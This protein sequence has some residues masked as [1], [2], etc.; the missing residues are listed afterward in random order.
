MCN[1]SYTQ[2]ERE[3]LEKELV[4]NVAKI[5]SLSKELAQLKVIYSEICLTYCI[6]MI[7]IIRYNM[8]LFKLHLKRQ[9]LSM[10]Y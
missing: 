4:V 6:E 2:N 3:V 1:L 8:K 9:A 7:F 5:D 10:T